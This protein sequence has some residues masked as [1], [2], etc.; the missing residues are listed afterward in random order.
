M[1]YS[2]VRHTYGTRGKPVLELRAEYVR[3]DQVGWVPARW[4]YDWIRKGKATQRA[5]VDVLQRSFD[6]KLPPKAFRA[7]LPTGTRVEDMIA[8]VRYVVG[9]ESTRPPVQDRG[10]DSIVRS[11]REDAE[12]TVGGAR[13]GRAGRRRPVW[14]P[15]NVVVLGVIL[16]LVSALVLYLRRRALISS[17]P[18]LPSEAGPPDRRSR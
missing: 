9:G 5:V 12:P 6:L 3:D 15:R 17:R 14:R 8:K 7:V 10:I 11:L 16:V 4:E 18:V 2:L 1:D 13:S